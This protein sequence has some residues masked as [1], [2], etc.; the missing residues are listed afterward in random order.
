MNYK[1]TIG[2]VN[3]VSGPM[4]NI[5]QSMDIVLK[6]FESLDIASRSAL[7]LSHINEARDILA[8]TN[9]E[10]DQMTV[11][12]A[13]VAEEERRMSEAAMSVENNMRAANGSAQGLLSTVRNIALA[14]GGTTLIKTAFSTSD[15]MAGIN[16]RLN[17]IED[18]NITAL[19]REILETS[20]L[21]GMSYM[22]NL[23]SMTR[24]GLL[25]GQAFADNSE[26]VRFTDLMNKNY[27][28]SGASSTERS[29][30]SYQ[31]SQAM[32]SGRL[33]GDEYRSII[34]NAPLLAQSIE[35]YMISEGFVGTMKE[36]ASEGMLTSEVIKNALFASADQIEQ[37]FSVMPMTWDR[38]FTVVGNDA[39]ESFTPVLDGIN[40]LANDDEIEKMRKSVKDTFDSLADASLGVLN[41]TADLLK[42]VYNGW[43]VLKPIVLG[44]TGAYVSFKLVHGALSTAMKVQNAIREIEQAQSIKS[45]FTKQAETAATVAQTTTT[46]GLTTATVAQT[47]A[48]TALNVAMLASPVGWVTAAVG[49]IGGT[50]LG[51]V[52][53]YNAAEE[54]AKSWGETNRQE[55]L[56]SIRQIEDDVSDSL[57]SA[58]TA[59]M[60]YE[61]LK[62]LAESPI[63]SSYV[64]NTMEDIVSDLQEIM[65]VDL[66][67][68][69]DR[70]EEAIRANM[71]A[72]E[73]LTES[74]YDYSIAQAHIDASKATMDTIIK[75]NLENDNVIN[76]A[77]RDYSTNFG[78]ILDLTQN[79]EIF[80]NDDFKEY[81]VMKSKLGIEIEFDDY[82]LNSSTY[83]GMLEEQG[84]YLRDFWKE[85]G[86]LDLSYVFNAFDAQDNTADNVELYKDELDKYAN[87]REDLKNSGYGKYIDGTANS[88]VRLTDH[89]KGFSNQLASTYNDEMVTAMQAQYLARQYN[90]LASSVDRSEQSFKAMQSITAQLNDLI[91]DMNFEFD[92]QRYAIDSVVGSIDEATAAFGRYAQAKAM[93]TAIQDKMS[94]IFTNSLEAQIQLDKTVSDYGEDDPYLAQ[95]QVDYKA[96]MRHNQEEADGLIGRLIDQYSILNEWGEIIAGNT[97][98]TAKN[99][100]K[101]DLTFMRQMVERSAIDKATYS[102]YKIEII[103]HNT[104]SSK[105]E[106][107]YMLEKLE[108]QLEEGV[109]IGS[110]GVRQ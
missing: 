20:N 17:L 36:W 93:A 22:D 91:P 4:K 6:S 7:D 19:K 73:E 12:C 51:L 54:A 53:N 88:V 9:T 27:I 18:G 16:A 75:N 65:E 107:D 45:L 72:L 102:D 29:S 10:V 68:N 106:A 57:V 14:A 2:I 109:S 67:S 32:A 21:A 55:L 103:N 52:S 43:S 64:Y 110:E 87:Y 83:I 90:D 48:Q 101:E 81:L 105:D 80:N 41:G 34:E 47:T 5:I 92:E 76:Q 24:L 30:A 46:T 35:N 94:E 104:I 108:K 69:W 79:R 82:R 23:Q 78:E 77:M 96:I 25:A 37:R 89:L 60:Y 98:T 59:V 70:S 61:Q 84:H 1:A 28:I 95:A 8:R 11:N 71:S 97:G 40:Q 74:Y 42:G 44:V 39:A 58:E 66:T 85:V 63:R 33:Q 26:I 31:L 15:V 62:S 100:S 13:R 99:T 86:L 50:I 49:L 38:I 56:D 3:Q